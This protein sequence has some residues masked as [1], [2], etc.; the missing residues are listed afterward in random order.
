M[1]RFALLGTFVRDESGQDLLE[2]GVL[3]A[4]IAIV[5]IGAVTKTGLS[6]DSMWTGIATSLAAVA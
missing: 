5:V 3:A 6:I 4:L 1:E 2:Y